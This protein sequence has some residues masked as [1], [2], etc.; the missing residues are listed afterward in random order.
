[1]SRIHRNLSIRGVVYPDADAAAEALGVTATQ[2]RAH[3][4]AGTLDRCGAGGRGVAPMPV[5]VRGV[6]YPSPAAAAHAFGIGVDAVYRRIE[7]GRADDIGL[8]NARGQHC[9]QPVEIGPLS[10]PSKSAAA[11]A[12]GLS[13]NYVHSAYARKSPKMLERVVAAAMAQAA[14]REELS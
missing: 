10:F 2:V 14:K 1:M 6:D 12:L 7:A 4:R 8:P 11:R 3:A 5:R 9:A 13:P